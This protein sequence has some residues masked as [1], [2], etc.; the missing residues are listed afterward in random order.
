MNPEN[1]QAQ[2]NPPKMSPQC[3]YYYRNREAILER[4]KA[5]K[6]WLTYYESNKDAI[7]ERRK[8]KRGESAA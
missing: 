2:L 6:R 5:K 3:S 4:E 7:A 1:T 8:K